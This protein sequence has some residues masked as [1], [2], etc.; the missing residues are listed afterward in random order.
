VSVLS[1]HPDG[2]PFRLTRGHRTNALVLALGPERFETGWTDAPEARRDYWRVET[3]EAE[4]L[5]LF[6]CRR[7]GDWFLHGL[8]G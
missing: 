3:D 8:F 2:P 6:R 1:I 4:R 5:W 7:T